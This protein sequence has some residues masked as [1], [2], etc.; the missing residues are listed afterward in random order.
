MNVVK[1]ILIP[2]LFIAAWFMA[3][4]T[5]CGQ[6]GK[7]GSDE[8]VL[9]AGGPHR[10]AAATHEGDDAALI[11]HA[12]DVDLVVFPTLHKPS[13]GSE[14]APQANALLASHAPRA[15]PRLVS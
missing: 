15:P 3:V 5:V 10:A 14:R 4:Q 8:E 7:L 12:T 11:P 2:I 1:R 9:V 6:T 13:Y